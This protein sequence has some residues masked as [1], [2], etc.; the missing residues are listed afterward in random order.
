M[1]NKFNQSLINE[2]A[3]KFANSRCQSSFSQLYHELHPLIITLAERA[4]KRAA[5]TGLNIPKEDFISFFNQGL[6]MATSKYDILLGDF[7]PRFKVNIKM[8][9]ADVW[10]LYQTR[11]KNN[12]R[13]YEKARFLSLDK[14]IGHYDSE[15]TTY[16]DFLPPSPSAEQ[17]YVEKEHIRWILSDFQRTNKK[18]ATV[19]QLLLNGLPNHVIATLLNESTYNPKVRKLIQRSRVKFGEYYQSQIK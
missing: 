15:S 17:E 8:R 18:Y 7:L 2:L 6:F 1:T 9:E 12:N 10:R 5:V 16:L 13:K 19:I 11:T 4:H 3:Y 14:T